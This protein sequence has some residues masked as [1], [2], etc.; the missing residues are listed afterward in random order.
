MPIP[1]RN[2]SITHASRLKNPSSL[3]RTH[4]R[5]LL[6]YA[7]IWSVVEIAFEFIS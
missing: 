2:N 3:M 5:L 1:M 4:H 6:T 7:S